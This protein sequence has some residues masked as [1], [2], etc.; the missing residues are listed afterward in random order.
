MATNTQALPH[1]VRM[2]TLAN[3]PVKG[4]RGIIDASD[5]TIWNWVKE[6]Q[7]PKGRKL[8]ARVTVWDMAEVESFLRGEW[9]PDAPE[10][11]KRGGVR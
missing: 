10:A 7:F 8:S 5:A 2:R 4:T 6:G 9:K 11:A 3:D 1:F